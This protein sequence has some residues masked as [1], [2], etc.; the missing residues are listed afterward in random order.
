MA[1]SQVTTRDTQLEK[2][3][4]GLL[5]LSLTNFA[6]TS[7]PAIA[8]GSV[9]EVG[10]S[11]FV[12][13][14]NEAITGWGGVSNDTDAYIKLVPGVGLVTA[15]FVEAAPTWSDAKQGWY[16]GNDRYVAGLHR[17]ASAA[18]YDDKVVFS[19]MQ[20]GDAGTINVDVDGALIEQ[21]DG[22]R[23]LVEVFEIGD[24]NMV[25]DVLITPAIGGI[26]VNNIRDVAV[27]I[28]ND[29]DTSRYPLVSSSVTGH[30]SGYWR[31]ATGT[32]E[33]NRLTGEQFDHT[34][35]DD[36][37]YNRGWITVWYEL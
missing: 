24:W 35:Y 20:S 16:D 7:E 26:A 25:A 8:A 27:I 21:N 4:I 22:D 28:R 34:N 33:L 6:N 19:E 3:R 15:E 11:L 5:Q 23:L 1:N 31:I 29:A 9:V 32:F 17:G 37:G 18:V 2:Q 12:F 36:T 10:G 14:S 30:V 13:T